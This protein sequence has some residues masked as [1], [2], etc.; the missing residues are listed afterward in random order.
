VGWIVLAVMGLLLSI[1]AQA[2][3][4]YEFYVTIERCLGEI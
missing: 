2:Q 1:P 4:A 3:A